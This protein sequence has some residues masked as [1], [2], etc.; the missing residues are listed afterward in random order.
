MIELRRLR[1]LVTLAMRLSYS[2]AA[3]EL[4]ISQSALTRAIQSLEQEMNL[5]LFDRDPAGVSLTEEGRRVVEKAEVVLATAKDFEHQVMQTSSRT[6]GRIRFGMTP[7]VARTLLPWTIPARL[8]A[9]P[10]FA[11]EV[12]VREAEALWYLLTAREIEFFVSAEWPLPHVLPVRIETLGSFPI[13]VIVREGHPLLTGPE[14]TG[15]PLLVSAAGSVTGQ[16]PSELLKRTAS[17]I[18]VFEDFG[19]LS[20]IVRTTDAIWLTS[21]YAVARELEAGT[22]CELPWKASAA[23]RFSVLMYSLDR[24]PQSPAALE[25]KQ[26]FRQEIRR[27]GCASAG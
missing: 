15:F 25:L 18:H 14:A 6:E 3:E 20:D 21:A 11:H 23:R 17:S 13:S 16:L 7:I 10:G 9:A 8:E 4:G 24:R 26:A 12:M 2:R 1:Y 27:L 19:S 22:F 5:R